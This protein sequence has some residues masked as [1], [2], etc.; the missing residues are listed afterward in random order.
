[1]LW[2]RR[3]SLYLILLP[4]SVNRNPTSPLRRK[5]LLFTGFFD[6]PRANEEEGGIFEA[7]PQPIDCSWC[8]GIEQQAFS[9]YS[10]L[11]Q[12][13]GIKLHHFIAR[14]W[15][16][17]VGSAGWNDHAR[18]VFWRCSQQTDCTWCNGRDEQAF[19]WYHSL[20]QFVAN[21]L[22]HLTKIKEK[23]SRFE[24]RKDGTTMKNRF[25]GMVTSESIVLGTLVEKAKLLFD[26]IFW[27][28]RSQTALPVEDC[29]LEDE[30]GVLEVSHSKNHRDGVFFGN[31][32]SGSIVLYSYVLIVETIKL[33]FNTFH[34]CSWRQSRL[35]VIT[36]NRWRFSIFTTPDGLIN[37]DEEWIFSHCR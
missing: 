32:P 1:M 27:L 2:Q 9:W 24:A 34:W 3:T 7:R 36:R 33:L 13:F 25:F 20:L 14:K 35:P 37:E 4:A 29:S 10:L 17:S 11:S 31:A 30:K 16:F 28:S 23:F 19:T 5:L 6:V 21:K 22:H 18:S 26:T 12:S 15:C 8:N